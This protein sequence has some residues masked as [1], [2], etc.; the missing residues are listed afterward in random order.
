[1]SRLKALDTERRLTVKKQRQSKSGVREISLNEV[2]KAI[3]VEVET[4]DVLNVRADLLALKS[5]PQL[6]GASVAVADELKLEPNVKRRIAE[7]P[8]LIETRKKVAME[9]FEG[10]T[11]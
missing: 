2:R 9:H 11:T 3:A 6:Y 5:G 4:A 8:T 10:F 7:K 1:M